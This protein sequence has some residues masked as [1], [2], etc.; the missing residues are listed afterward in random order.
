MNE[1]ISLNSMFVASIGLFSS[2]LVASLSY[3][4]SKKNQLNLQ[5]SKW[6]EEY[7]RFTIKALS[8]NV[9]DNS[10]EDAKDRL[11]EGFN[12]LLLVASAKVVK[13]MMEFHDHIKPS[14]Q[15]SNGWI[16]EHDRILRELVLAMREDIFKKQ[17]KEYPNIHVIGGK[18]KQQ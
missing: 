12:S 17:D 15:R 8:D 7:Y 2:V 5:I 18:K 10:S 11:A 4:F 16:E 9:I 3:Y 14:T 6:K 13:K 1:M